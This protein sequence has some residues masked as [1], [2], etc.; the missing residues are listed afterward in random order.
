MRSVAAAILLC[1][2]LPCSMLLLS[3][4]SSESSGE[5]SG[6]DSHLPTMLVNLPNGRSIRAEIASTQADQERGLMF[7]SSLAPDRGMLFVFDRSGLYPFWMYHTLIPLDIVWM[8]SAHNIVFI[9]ANT[10]ACPSEN[11]KDCPN[12]GSKDLSHLSQYVLELAGGQAAANSL[13]VGDK[14]RF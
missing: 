3:S 14:L 13:K 11:S 1:I 10:P 4:C 2:T 5:S 6:T 9:S 8:D 12:Y 7:R